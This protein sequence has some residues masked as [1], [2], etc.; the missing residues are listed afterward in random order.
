[1]NEERLRGRAGAQGAVEDRILPAVEGRDS[2]LLERIPIYGMLPMGW[3]LAQDCDFWIR[4]HGSRAPDR[5]VATTCR[6]G[7]KPMVSHEV[8]DGGLSGDRDA[9]SVRRKQAD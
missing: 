8:Q 3:I 5:L 7:A 6:G 4:Q 1:M 9:K 2:I